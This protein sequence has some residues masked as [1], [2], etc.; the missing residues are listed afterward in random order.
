MAFDS[1]RQTKFMTTK[2][3]SKMSGI[4]PAASFK[5]I[6]HPHGMILPIF[7]STQHKWKIILTFVDYDSL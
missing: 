6:V 5:G 4:G 1:M 7:I 3:H 2:N